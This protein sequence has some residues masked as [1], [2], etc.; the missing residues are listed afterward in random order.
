VQTRDAL[1]AENAQLRLRQRD[2]EVRTL[3]YEALARENAQLRGLREALPPV[4]EKWLVAEVVNVEP[5]SL[6]QSVLDGS[7]AARRRAVLAAWGDPGD[8]GASR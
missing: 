5:N 8:V 7:F 4:A 6:R 3:R 1:R 2:L